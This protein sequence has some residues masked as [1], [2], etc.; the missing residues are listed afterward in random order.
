MEKYNFQQIVDDLIE[1][2]REIYIPILKKMENLEDWNDF[3]IYQDNKFIIVRKNK[4]INTRKTRL[5]A[6]RS[7]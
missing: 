1:D 3:I 7:S 4:V 5:R 2:F 6:G